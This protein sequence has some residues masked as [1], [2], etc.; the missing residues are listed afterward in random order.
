MKYVR[1][2]DAATKKAKQESAQGDGQS[3]RTT[4]VYTE[5]LHLENGPLRVAIHSRKTRTHLISTTDRAIGC[6]WKFLENTG[7]VIHD[8]V[9]YAAVIT[10]KH[11]KCSH[12]FSA[13]ALPPVL[14]AASDQ[15]E[16]EEEDSD[17]SESWAS[18]SSQS[19][20]EDNSPDKLAPEIGRRRPCSNQT[21]LG[22]RFM[23]CRLGIGP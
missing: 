1:Q 15:K 19:E 21:V 23:P 10:E 7:Q 5:T 18:E 17:Q 4:V 12:C 22:D 20:L 6:G 14:G 16:A 8:K 9:A 2:L 13:Y 3:T 11:T